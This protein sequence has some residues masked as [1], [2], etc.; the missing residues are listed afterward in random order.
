MLGKK[1]YKSSL[2]LVFG[3]GGF[4]WFFFNALPIQENFTSEL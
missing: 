4:F 3:F 1:A 2:F